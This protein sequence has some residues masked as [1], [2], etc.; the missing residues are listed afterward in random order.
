MKPS[1]RIFKIFSQLRQKKGGNKS[2][3]RIEAVVKYLD[4]VW[5]EEQISL[6]KM[7]WLFPN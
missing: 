7:L 5:L 3:D 2:H 1:E 4:E 6:Q